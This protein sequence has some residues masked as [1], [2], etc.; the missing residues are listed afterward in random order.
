MRL[1]L[2][3]LTLEIPDELQA[4][5]GQ[6]YRREDRD[7]N[8]MVHVTDDGDPAEVIAELRQRLGLI[9]KDAT[10]SEPEPAALPDREG[11]RYSFA[12][13]ADEVAGAQA[14]FAL[15]APDLI[16]FGWQG[17]GDQAAADAGLDALLA[18]VRPSADAPA[19]VEAEH[20]RWWVGAYAFDLPAA[21][22]GPTV[23]E[24]RGVDRRIRARVELHPFGADKLELD[25]YAA[26]HAKIGRRLVARED[27]PIIYGDLIRLELE[28]PDGAAHFFS[29]SVQ[30]YEV[31]NP[32]RIRQVEVEVE[33]PGE[34]TDTIRSVHEKLLASLDLEGA[35]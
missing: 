14:L 32:I 1:R 4:L 35:A 18:S 27:V 6:N 10:S 19:T 3:D 30:G 21:F 33:G 26:R 28:D 11:L 25:G 7:E 12:V 29:A 13:P 8:V 31:G 22:V 17:P 9:F 34:L 2:D 15:E 20:R 24:L 5:D 23:A 16:K